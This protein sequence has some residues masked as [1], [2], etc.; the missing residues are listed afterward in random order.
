MCARVERRRHLRAALVVLG[1]DRRDELARDERRARARRSDGERAELDSPAGRR[2]CVGHVGTDQRD[3]SV[4]LARH[5]CR[6][7]DR[8]AR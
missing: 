2:G 4:R 7:G 5:V 3:Q 1:A 8:K 6:G